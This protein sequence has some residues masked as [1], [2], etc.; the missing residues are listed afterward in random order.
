VL[1]ATIVDGGKEK[2]SYR[3]RP[4]FFGRGEEVEVQKENS[5]VTLKENGK[6]LWSATRH[7]GAPHLLNHK[8]GQTL[9]QAVMEQRGN[10]A[11]FFLAIK[12]PKFLARHDLDGC[13]GTSKLAP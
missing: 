3:S 10:P 7:Y 11:D 12:V 6:V 5:S 9:E 2:V 4:G 1:E 8:D 13:Y